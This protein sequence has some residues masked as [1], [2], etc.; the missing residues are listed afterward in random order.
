MS[1]RNKVCDNL[2]AEGPAEGKG[3][4]AS[5]VETALACSR[6]GPVFPSLT[7]RHWAFPAVPCLTGLWPATLTRQKYLVTH[8]HGAIFKMGNQQRPAVQHK[9][10]CSV[11]CGSLDG[12][13]FGGQR[14]HTHAG[15]N[16][17]TVRLKLSQR[18]LLTGYECVH[19]Y[20]CACVLSP[21]R[22][23]VTSWTV[24]HQAPMSMEFS[25]QEYWSGLPF[26]FPGDLPDPGIK[27][28]SLAS[29]G[30]VGRFFTTE[31]PG[32]P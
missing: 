11:L 24:A 5:Q 2:P 1:Q 21:V 20:E 13:G 26:S 28:T 32:K 23:F 18:C 8:V 16:P 14:V 7:P 31:P 25:R 3:R 22:L 15:L 9:E 17:F 19:V 10:L 27:P 12:R 4:K 29:P 6:T 30:L